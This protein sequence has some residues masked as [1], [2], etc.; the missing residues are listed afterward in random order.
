M[1]A[2]QTTSYLFIELKRRRQLVCDAEAVAHDCLIAIITSY[3]TQTVLQG[4][5]L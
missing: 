4:A 1:C 3:M 2:A 5:M